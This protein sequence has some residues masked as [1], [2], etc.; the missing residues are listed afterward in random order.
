MPNH[1]AFYKTSNSSYDPKPKWD[2]DIPKISD[3][4]AG[5]ELIPK[6]MPPNID[7]TKYVLQ[8]QHDEAV[9]SRQGDPVLSA[10]IL[11]V[12]FPVN[13]KDIK[14]PAIAKRGTDNPLYATSSLNIGKEVPMSHQLP[15]HYFPKNNDFTNKY[16][17]SKPRYTGLQT[18]PT[19]SKV[20]QKFDAYY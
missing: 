11:P 15:E 10:H 1:N 18:M 7:H 4:L 14:Y 16:T 3:V 17:D 5:K 8:R 9:R 19:L 13:A 20:H 12:K 2:G 6:P